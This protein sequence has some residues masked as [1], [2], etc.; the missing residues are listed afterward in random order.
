M[1]KKVGGVICFCLLGSVLLFGCGK[2]GGETG[3]GSGGGGDEIKMFY[4]SA[5][6]L[7]EADKP[8]YD[9]VEKRFGVKLKVEVPPQSNASERL[10][11][12]MASGNYPDVI[13]FMDS[14]DKSYMDGVKNGII[15]PVTKYLEKAPNIQ[16]YTYE[17]SWDALRVKDNEI[18]GIPVTSVI[19]ND[20][21]AVR[22]DWLKKVGLSLPEDGK[23]TLGEFTEIIR[24]FTFDDPDGNG[25]N[26]T[27]G[28]GRYG[29][30][31]GNIGLLVPSPYGSLGWQKYEGEDYPYMDKM[32]SLKD[33]LYKRSLEYSA[34]IFKDGLVDPNS[35]LIK[36]AQAEERFAQG[37]TG[38]LSFFPGN[39]PA[40]A[41]T[42]KSVSPNAEID[43][44]VGIKDESGNVVTNFEGTG[45]YGMWGVTK[46]AKDP[47][48][49]V[50]FFD[51]LV[52]DEGWDLNIYG[53][54]GVHY[55]VVD[56][57]KVATDLFPKLKH[58][59]MMRRSENVDL[60]ANELS[61]SGEWLETASKWL[62]RAIENVTISEDR[63]YLPEAVSD[64]AYIDAKSAMS[65]TVTKIVLGEEPV[66]A[67]DKALDNWYKSGG[68]TYIEQMN[69]YIESVSE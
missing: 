4:T 8:W 38:V 27:Y 36:R 10:Q 25:K 1:G 15:I 6:P 37:I 17:K 54:S 42:L 49:I 39:I 48:K 66:T 5:Q 35:P 11:L 64:G 29:A 18:F 57:K 23:V 61:M 3:G 56:G 26:D 60:W 21:Y 67:Y 53:V 63:G 55:N 44:I 41:K 45:L 19:R 32:Y 68:K 24:R 51:R 13:R 47:Q 22:A 69:N 28:L 43:Y 52:S 7:S 2:K 62:N 14:R 40:F 31:D 20:G 50:D 33:N 16:K 34:K 65:A 9:E 59:G 12:V 58:N 30:G 46:T